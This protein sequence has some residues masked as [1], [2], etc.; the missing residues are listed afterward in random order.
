MTMYMQSVFLP[1]IFT[2]LLFVI[3]VGTEII[4]LCLKYKIHIIFNILFLYNI[5]Y[6]NSFTRAQYKRPWR[7]NTDVKDKWSSEYRGPRRRNQTNWSLQESL[8]VHEK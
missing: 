4:L 5:G 3:S 7:W 8:E 2:V 1:S 6:K